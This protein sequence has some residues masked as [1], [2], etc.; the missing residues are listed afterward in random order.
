MLNNFITVFKYLSLINNTSYDPKKIIVLLR[1]KFITIRILNNK[2][3]LT[4]EVMSRGYSII[5]NFETQSSGGNRSIIIIIIPSIPFLI[6][7]ST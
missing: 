1:L 3:L 7:P 6:Y 5:L 4:Y 2:I